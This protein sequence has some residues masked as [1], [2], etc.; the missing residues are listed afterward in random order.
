M[1]RGGKDNGQG[2]DDDAAAVNAEDAP[3]TQSKRYQFYMLASH[4]E[5]GASMSTQAIRAI[6]VSTLALL[7]A[8]PLNSGIMDW[9]ED[10]ILDVEIMSCVEPS[11]RNIHLLPRITELP[12]E[13]VPDETAL[14]HLPPGRM[15]RARVLRYRIREGS[16][17]DFIT[18]G[19]TLAKIH[20]WQAHDSPKPTVYFLPATRVPTPGAIRPL[21]QTCGR[22][23]R[24][25]RVLLVASTASDCDTVPLR[26]LCLFRRLNI[27]R[28][29]DERDREDALR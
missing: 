25:A 10:H 29:A 13:T 14:T 11:V 22:L 23:R 2:C 28:E 8:R 4:S 21:D 6:V 27:V 19:S 5:T 3:H 17:E 12:D 15:I 16:L 18:G 26:G 24:G 20:P 1:R 7:A 9:W